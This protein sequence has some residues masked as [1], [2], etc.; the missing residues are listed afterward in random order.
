MGNP[1]AADPKHPDGLTLGYATGPFTID[2]LYPLE[3]V[4]EQLNSSLTEHYADLVASSE[5]PF[6][7]EQEIDI[8][9]NQTEYELPADLVQLRGFWY[10]DPGDDRTVVPINDRIYMHMEDNGSPLEVGFLNGAPTYRMQMNFVVLNQIPLA[11]NLGGMLCRYIKWHN[12]LSNDSQVI[13][14]QFAQI[15]Q[16]CIIVGAAITLAETKQQ[17]TVQPWVDE[18]SRW[19]ERLSI[20]VRNTI[21]PPFA[22][23]M[24]QPPQFRSN[25]RSRRSRR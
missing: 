14:T 13:E 16:Q 15:L 9:A 21:N 1:I 22:M 20:L 4:N 3:E 7:D 23:I 17:L 2:A 8:I 12:W 18:L 10:K 5:L 6:A 24:V 25:L 19:K 11:N